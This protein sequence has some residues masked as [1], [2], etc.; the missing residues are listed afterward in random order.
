[1]ALNNKT[2]QIMKLGMPQALIG[3]G[4]RS[5]QEDSIFPA[6]GD[7]NTSTR[8]FLV[9]DG[10]G[11]HDNGDVASSIVCSTFGSNLSDIDHD[12][13]T[14]D[15]FDKTLTAAYDALDRE[16]SSPAS[17]RKMGT[18]LAMLYLNNKEATI[19]HIGDS[20]VYHVR[21]SAESAILYQTRDHSLVNDLVRAEVI[22]ADEAA[23]YP[24]R[25]VITRAMQPRLELR[26]SADVHT[27]QDVRAGDYFF[28]CSDGV[29]ESLTNKALVDILRRDISDADK[30]DA[31]RVLCEVLSGDNFSAYLVP[32]VEGMSVVAAAEVVEKVEEPV[33]EVAKVSTPVTPIAPVGVTPKGNKRK[34]RNI[35]PLNIILL[36]VAIGAIITAI[37]LGL[38]NGSLKVEIVTVEGSHAPV[39][40]SAIEDAE[41]VEQPEIVEQ[42]ES[43]EDATAVEET[44]EV[45]DTDECPAK[46][47]KHKPTL[48]RGM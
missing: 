48:L 46:S 42:V 20:R 43:V 35:T 26:Y 10:M 31:I 29:H 22:T 45:A 12:A 34:S 27:I 17:C 38:G 7:A 6:K 1:M 13:F 3:V 30:V 44:Q 18:T 37:W 16:D 23:D 33:Q 47:E 4:G 39:V 36:C 19:A 14:V 25:N 8:L 5:N 32:V 11:G 24:R 41:H 40:Q 28:L 2:F 9:C 21:P 15:M